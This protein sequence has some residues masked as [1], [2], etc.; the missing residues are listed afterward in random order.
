MGLLKEL[1]PL[2][3][4]KDVAIVL[5]LNE[6][7]SP[8]L[9]KLGKLATTKAKIYKDYKGVDAFSGSINFADRI[10]NITWAKDQILE[11]DAMDYGKCVKCLNKTFEGGWRYAE[12]H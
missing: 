12:K 3:E 9:K 6:K 2:L 4:N 7:P 1:S 8:D 5:P 10:F 11:I